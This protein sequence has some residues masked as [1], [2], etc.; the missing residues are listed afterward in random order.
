[1]KTKFKLFT[2]LLTLIIVNC[3]NEKTLTEY[4][5]SDQDPVLDCIEPGTD[6][7][8]NKLLNEALFS[9]EDDIK[10]FYR[11]KYNPEGKLDLV[12]SEF[13]ARSVKGRVPFEDL[14]TPHTMEVFNVLKSKKEIWNPDNSENRLNYY[15]SFFSCIAANVEDKDLKTTLNALVSTHSMSQ[16]LFIE[17]LMAKYRIV[18]TDNY[19]RA[20]TAFDLFYSRLFEIDPTKVKERILIEYY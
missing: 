1:M 5:F 20:Y 2:F 12:Y 3:N 15:N 11:N 9:F 17:P 7:L 14:V 18:P 4:R 16:R 6:G 19:L 13:F 8:D 10:T